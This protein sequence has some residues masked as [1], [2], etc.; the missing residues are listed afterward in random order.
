MSRSAPLAAL[1]RL[2]LAGRYG[3]LVSGL[4]LY[5]LSLR[6]MLDARVGLAPWEAFHL[7]VT[8]QLPLSIGLV[9]IL[10]GVLVAAFTAL[11]LRERIGPGTVINVLLIGLFLDLLGPL[12]PDPASLPA[13]W[14]QFVLGVA[15]LG[16]ATGTYVAAG[17]GAGPRDG[18]VLG[19]SRVTGWPVARVRTGTELLVLGLGWLLG[20]LVGWGTLV[21]ALGSGPAM[22][23]GLGL[24]GLGRG[25]NRE[26]APVPVQPAR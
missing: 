7:G 11:R 10:T 26:T 6:L 22:S 17:L 21:F 18:L 1:T 8:R 25:G 12:V 19:L 9:S 16:L 4:F 2:P 15:L 3:L 20:G 24:Y 5:G 23:V 14:V 13:R